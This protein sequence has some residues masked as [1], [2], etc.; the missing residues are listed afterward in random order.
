MSLANC[1]RCG[2]VYAAVPG[3]RELCQACLKEEE[4]NYL[5]V[6][7]FFT[8]RPSAT[9]QEISQETGVDIKEIYRYVRENRLKLAKTDTGIY[10]EGC[11]I[12]ISQG[13]VCEKCAQKLA[14]EL[15][16]DID[17][18]KG[19]GAK[20]TSRKDQRPDPKYLKERRDQG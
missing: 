15:K 19:Q 16:Q 13:R 8:K 1:S 7:H 3:S 6:F 12:P 11:G 10:C 14:Q 4:S 2:K 9:A 5:K 17:K 18:Y 20:D